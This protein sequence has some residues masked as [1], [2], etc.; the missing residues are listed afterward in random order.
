M[1]AQPDRH[2]TATALLSVRR[3]YLPKLPP[4]AMAFAEALEGLGLV[5]TYR[6]PGR[7]MREAPGGLWRAYG[8][9]AGMMVH[10]SFSSAYGLVLLPRCTIDG[11]PAPR[12]PPAFSGFT[13]RFSDHVPKGRVSYTFDPINEGSVDECLAVLRHHLLGEGKPPLRCVSYRKRG[14]IITDVCRYSRAK[15]AAGLDPW[16]PIDVD[17][18]A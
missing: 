11:E 3:G 2:A 6:T 12:L 13:V 9:Q 5:S 18:H 10:N 14:Q 7:I 16:E 4:L 8:A 1:D 17:A 15:A